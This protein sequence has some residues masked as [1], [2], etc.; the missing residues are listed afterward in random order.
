M[1]SNPGN[2]VAPSLTLDVVAIEKGA[3]GSPST[4]VANFT[5]F[6]LDILQKVNVIDR[7]EIELAYYELPVRNIC[8]YNT[9]TSFSSP[10][11]GQL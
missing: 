8:P 6:S 9:R 2:G 10:I 5:T 11:E 1:W 7:L 3:Y 4:K